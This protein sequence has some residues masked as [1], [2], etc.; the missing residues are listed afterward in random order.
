MSLTAQRKP[1]ICNGNGNIFPLTFCWCRISGGLQA[2]RGCGKCRHSICSGKSPCWRRH[3]QWGEGVSEGG[4]QGDRE[5][6]G[7]VITYLI[8][9]YNVKICSALVSFLQLL[10]LMVAFEDL[11]AAVQGQDINCNLTL[12]SS[13][14][15]GQTSAFSW[16]SFYRSSSESCS[17]S[18]LL[19]LSW[20]NFSKTVH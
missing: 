15:T 14:A 2:R 12:V 5:G 19:R 3:S 1:H 11:W 18:S 17:Q 6:E 4:L 7:R 20:N 10:W 13:P 8:P 9:F 16:K